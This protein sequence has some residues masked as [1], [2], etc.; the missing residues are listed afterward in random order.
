LREK[1]KHLI[2]EDI[3]DDIY[4][5]GLNADY[6]DLETEKKVR[7]ILWAGKMI[8]AMT[9]EMAYNSFNKNIKYSK[10]FNYDNS[11]VHVEPVGDG[12]KLKS[13]L[14]AEKIRWVNDLIPQR[15]FKNTENAKAELK[16]NVLIPKGELSME[17]AFSRDACFLFENIF[18]AKDKGI[19]ISDDILDVFKKAQKKNDRSK[20]IDNYAVFGRNKNNIA[21]GLAGKWLELDDTNTKALIRLIKTKAL[22]ISESNIP[23]QSGQSNKKGKC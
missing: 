8:K 15:Y 6:T 21:N 12:Y 1:F 3:K 13:K 9:F 17:E 5:I 14:H 16:N 20:T 19:D 2:S 4:F 7:K 10:M 23:V 18:F 11:P 22:N